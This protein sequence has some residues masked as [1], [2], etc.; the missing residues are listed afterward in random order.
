MR[1]GEEVQAALRTF[2]ARWE[3]YAGSER[4]EAQTFLNELFA[5]YGSDRKQVATFEDAHASSGIMDCHWPALVIVE[6][7]A[8][9]KAD[10]LAE[11]RKQALDYWRH[12]SNAATGLAAPPYV[13]LCAFGRF[14]VWE[15]GRFPDAPRADFT[16]AELPERYDTLLFLTGSGDEP[17]FGAHYKELTTEAA[18]AMADLF[19][20]LVER[21]AAA[22]ETLQTFVLQMVW[23]LFAEDLGLLSGHPVQQIVEG[24]IHHPDRS[25]FVELGAL[26]DVLNDPTDYGRQGVLAGTQYV[27]GELFAAPAKVHLNQVE[28]QLLRRAAEF[29]WRRVNP[30]IFGSLMEKCLAERRWEL[31]AHYTHEA[32][33]MKIVRPTIVQPWRDRIEAVA[34]PAQARQLLEELCAFRVLDP[35][36][37]CGNFLYVAYR[38]LR[39]LENEA[40][41][42]ITQLAAATGMPLPPQPWPYY[43]LR[44]LHGIDIEPISAFLARV[45]LWMGHR[46]AMDLYGPAEPVLPLVDLSGIRVGDALF[47]P[48]P[49]TDCIVG[50]PPFL[51]SQHLRKARGDAYIDRLKTTFGVGVKDYCVYW[52]RR[53]HDHLAAGQRAGLVGTNSIAQNRARSA[54]LQYIV[55]N[56]GVIT[57]AVS[58]QKWPGEA[59]VHVSLV[60]WVRDPT[61]PP[62]G[63]LLDGGPVPEITPEL[64]SAATSTATAARL[65]QNARRC[66]QGPIP[67][68]DGFIVSPG[69][70]QAL[71]ARSEADYRS[72]VRPY[73]TGEDI[74]EDP[75]QRPRRWIID[76]GSLPLEEAIHF[77]GALDIVRE[78]VKPARDLNARKARRDRWWQFGEKAVGMRAVT[79]GLERYIVG[80][81]QGKRLLLSWQDKR[82]CPSNLTYVFAFD[83]DAEMGILSSRVHGAWARAMSSTLEDRLRYT[84]TSVFETFVWPEPTP[85]QRQRIAAAS[86]AVIQTRQAV[87]LKEQIGLTVLYNRL[88]EG[89]YVHIRDAHL[90]LDRA[91]VASYGWPESVAQDDAELVRRLFAL[92]KQVATGATPYAPF[93]DTGPGQLALSDFSVDQQ[94]LA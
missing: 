59:K 60:N 17:L 2:V 40:K 74:A 30:T 71:L 81:A 35:A 44:N 55:D 16:L 58:T 29:D 66:F 80:M 76:F 51:G 52:F 47:M 84:P 65:P 33:I 94:P 68:G 63:C 34:T 22:P 61:V 41:V 15:P 91:V 18:Q 83:G 50:N 3:S 93:P 21:Q 48:W 24:L 49:A 20:A 23:C 56:G 25:S 1:S 19:Q 26:F 31:G 86:I 87:C 54:S 77:H 88:D 12:S 53:A 43:P 38:E 5:C 28:L 27:N 79:A 57:D 89:A 32:D 42:R 72:V 64:R 78:R 8:P 10:K 36:C 14:E 90:K 73:L 85:A 9:Q 67:V 6:M 37:G 11:H 92:N 70:A 4:G 13:V 7:K 62:A 82:T 69:E 39:A 45:T 46:Q 75:E